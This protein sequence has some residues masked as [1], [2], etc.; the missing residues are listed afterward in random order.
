MGR[1]SLGKWWRYYQVAVKSVNR[2]ELTVPVNRR[3]KKKDIASNTA[4][5]LLLQ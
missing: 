3:N 5:S 1:T 4:I 2:R